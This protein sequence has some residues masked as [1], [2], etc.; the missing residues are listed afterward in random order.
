MKQSFRK[1]DIREQRRI[2]PERTEG[3]VSPVIAPGCCSEILHPE[4]RIKSSNLGR[5][6][7]SP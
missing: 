6:L 7:W 4:C 3:G 5:A 2:I 1:L